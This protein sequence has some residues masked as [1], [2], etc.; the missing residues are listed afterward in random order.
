MIKGYID[1]KLFITSD[2][3][4]LVRY[5]LENEVKFNGAIKASYHIPGL[6]YGDYDFINNKWECKDRK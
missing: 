3:I 2:D 6:I 1:D 5:H 4:S